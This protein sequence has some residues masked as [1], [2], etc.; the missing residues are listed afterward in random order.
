MGNETE[1]NLFDEPA[2][3]D[4]STT[5]SDEK[6]GIEPLKEI[7]DDPVEEA[8]GNEPEL[9]NAPSEKKMEIPLNSIDEQA[10]SES[11]A[12]GPLN[13]TSNENSDPAELD[14]S[15]D[16]IAVEI[17]LDNPVVTAVGNEHTIATYRDIAGRSQSAARG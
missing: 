4:N 6:E 11:D 14:L 17:A 16:D 2:P 13:D 9:S 10:D 1:L 5:G 7:Q 12:A 3:V 8:A 15:L